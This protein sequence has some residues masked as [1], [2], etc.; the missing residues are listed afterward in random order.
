M[1]K[2]S[3]KVLETQ[4]KQCPH[5]W[6]KDRHVCCPEC[7]L[8]LVGDDFM[9]RKKKRWVDWEDIDDDIRRGD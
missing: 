8:E 9:K 4:E 2:M 6:D 3:T 5:G 7:Y 1:S